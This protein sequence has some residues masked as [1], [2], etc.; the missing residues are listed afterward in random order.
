MMKQE[1]VIKISS[2]PGVTVR[3]PTKPNL[4]KTVIKIFKFIIIERTIK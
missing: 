4:I 2:I 3:V 1:Y